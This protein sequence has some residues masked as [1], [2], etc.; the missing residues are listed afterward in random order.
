M[1]I[2]I[3]TQPDVE[4]I[5]LADLR[6]HLGIEPYEVDSA[7]NGTHPHD[8]MIMAM[9]G[10][11]REWAEQFTGLSIALKTY[12]LALDE[13]PADEDMELPHPPVVSIESVVYVTTDSSG[14]YVD[15]T[16][17]STLYALDRHQ[18][19]SGAGWLSPAADANWP[20]PSAVIN[21]VKIRYRA[22]YQV[23]EPDS[24]AEDAD[25]LPYAIRAA[26]LVMVDH[27]YENRGAVG[28]KSPNEWPFAAEALLRPLRV[29]LGMA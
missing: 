16:I 13:F 23:P 21:A 24:S 26:L 29:R 8:A 18:T 20:A 15:E 6:K 19:E 14:D 17:S 10:A 27:L 4:P 7:G 22:G 28:S 25:A 11:A 3:V 12:E 9:L 5:T 2:R 1:G